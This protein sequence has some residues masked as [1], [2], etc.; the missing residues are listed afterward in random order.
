VTAI[1]SAFTPTPGTLGLT[2]VWQPS[3][4]GLLGAS[5]DPSIS[6]QGGLMTAGTVYLIK[7]QPRI[8]QTISNLW[9]SLNT[10]GAGASTGCFTGLYSSA[11]TELSGSADIA[12][13]LT[14]AIGL[15]QCPLLTPQ[16]VTVGNFYWAAIVENLAT[17]QATLWRGVAPQQGNS[18]LTAATFKYATNG[19]AASVLPASITPASNSQAAA[20]AFWVGWS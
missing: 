17:T 14:T 4:N 6:T 15:V 16:P 2:G 10:L 5:W 12:S 1:Q 8:N 19:T 7:I 20:L 13:Q 9:W 11:G 18:N 3:D